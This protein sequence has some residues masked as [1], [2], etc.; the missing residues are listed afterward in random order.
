MPRRA[1]TLICTT[2]DLYKD[3]A[4]VLRLRSA[5]RFQVNGGSKSTRFTSNTIRLQ[6][7]RCRTKIAVGNAVPSQPG[8]SLAPSGPAKGGDPMRC[9][10]TTA[11]L[12]QLSYSTSVHRHLQNDKDWTTV[13][14]P[15]TPARTSWAILVF[16]VAILNR[17][18]I[19]VLSGILYK[20]MSFWGQ[21]L[22]VPAGLED[23]RELWN[24]VSTRGCRVVQTDEATITYIAI[25]WVDLLL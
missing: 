19:A 24:L 6:R 8:S 5:T 16:L 9:S 1:E 11:L 18:S 12:V 21:H 2:S 4:A 17:L 3:T 20:L 22:S 15:R 25:A 14:H 10:G 13:C 7:Y 23:K